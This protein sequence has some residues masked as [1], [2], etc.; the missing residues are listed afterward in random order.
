VL[1]ATLVVAHL[2]CTSGGKP[3]QTRAPVVDPI[4]CA[5]D[6]ADTGGLAVDAA[7]ITA[8]T[9]VNTGGRNTEHRALIHAAASR[10]TQDPPF[11][12]TQ[13]GRCAVTTIHAELRAGDALAWSQDLVLRPICEPVRLATPPSFACRKMTRIDTTYDPDPHAKAQWHFATGCE[14]TITK[15]PPSTSFGVYLQRTP[16]DPD[17]DLRS[18]SDVF[19]EDGNGDLDAG[20]DF[21]VEEKTCAPIRVDAVVSHDGAIV[22]TGRTTYVPDCPRAKPR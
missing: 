7:S 20:Y 12:E 21:P 18:Q 14:L 3:V 13:L 19:Q 22:W 2:A 5:I 10:W 9:I 11:E 4:T 15:P 8:D 16:A 17:D 6:V 1:A